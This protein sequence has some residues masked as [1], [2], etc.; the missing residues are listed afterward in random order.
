MIGNQVGKVDIL[1]RCLVDA[2]ME[3][4]KGAIYG[5]DIFKIH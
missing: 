1:P 3:S 2:S 4:L 5:F